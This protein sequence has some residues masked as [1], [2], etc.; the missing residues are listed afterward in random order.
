M[1]STS[2]LRQHLSKF[3]SP[4]P[5]E[6][7]A[8]ESKLRIRHLLKDQVY[9]AEGDVCR[10]I[11]IVMSGSVRMFYLIKGEER[12]KDF[13]FEGQFTGSI[14]SLVTEQPAKF[15]VAALEDTTMFEISRDDFFGL[16]DKYKTWERF[17]RLYI[18][19][20]FIYK[21]KREASLLFDSSLTRYESLLREQ[22]VHAQRIP[23]KYLA[24][25][26]GIKP[27]SL[28]RIRKTIAKRKT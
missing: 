17:G 26:L 2:D 24:S 20:M 5:A 16:C 21:E 15:S 25:Y 14:A 12:C 22:P 18:Q 28:S 4:T 3:I 11:G 23:L 27:E 7:R 10:R 1:T 9:L 6:W 13:Q 19:Q 8:F